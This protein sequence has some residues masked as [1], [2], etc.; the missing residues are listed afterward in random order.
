MP[1]SLW[2][3]G[4]THGI[5]H[6]VLVKGKALLKYVVFTSKTQAVGNTKL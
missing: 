5:G 4:F 3:C 1:K 6:L 2:I